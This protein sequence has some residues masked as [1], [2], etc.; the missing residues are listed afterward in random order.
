MNSKSYLLVLFVTNL[1]VIISALPHVP[2]EEKQMNISMSHVNRS[3]EAADLGIMSQ[4]T[5]LISFLQMETNLAAEEKMRM[6]H[7]MEN[8][9]AFLKQLKQLLISSRPRYG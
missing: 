1:I 2:K 6:E 4:V 3:M 5:D 9:H 8:L 7:E